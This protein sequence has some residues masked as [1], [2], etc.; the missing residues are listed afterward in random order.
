MPLTSCRQYGWGVQGAGIEYTTNQYAVVST[1][2]GEFY[3]RHGNGVWML[4]A[5]PQAEAVGVFIQFAQSTVVDDDGFNMPPVVNGAA[6]VLAGVFQH[7]A[8]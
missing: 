3:S 6:Q 7:G 1:Q 2:Q 8:Q 5:Q 4:V